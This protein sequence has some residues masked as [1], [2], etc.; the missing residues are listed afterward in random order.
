MGDAIKKKKKRWRKE[1]GFMFGTQITFARLLEKKEKKRKEKKNKE[2]NF[3]VPRFVNVFF[4][5]LLLLPTG[6]IAGKTQ[7]SY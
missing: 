1:D 5:L 4:F 7:F 3:Q 6:M 2:R